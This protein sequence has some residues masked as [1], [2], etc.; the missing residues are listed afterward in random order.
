[1]SKT[2]YI[3]IGS[4]LGERLRNCRSA[5][6]KIA[7]L[8]NTRVL[9]ESKWREYPALT[10]D[11]GES[12]PSFINGAIKIETEFNPEELLLKLQEIEKSMGRPKKRNKWA[13]R[14]IDMDILLYNDAVI[15]TETL[16]IPH[17]EIEKRVFVLEPLCDIGVD[18][19]SEV[20]K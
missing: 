18:L 16:T 17:P 20:C 9:A 15:E 7:S 10:L 5:V 6:Q 12:Q 2:A 8:K 13:P 1:M 19:K 14:I 3:G 11:A 4:N